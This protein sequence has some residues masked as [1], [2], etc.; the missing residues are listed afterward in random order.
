[1]V[2]TSRKRESRKTKKSRPPRKSRAPQ[3]RHRFRRNSWEPWTRGHRRLSSR[4]RAAFTSEEWRALRSLNKTNAWHGKNN[5][6][7]PGTG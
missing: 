7:P 5:A 4:E 1:M 6:I 2:S 3:E